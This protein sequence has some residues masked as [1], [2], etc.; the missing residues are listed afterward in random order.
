VIVGIAGLNPT[1]G[2]DVCLSCLSCGQ[3]PLWQADH[4]LTGVLPGGSVCVT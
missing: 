1:E 2:T 3:Q 4:S